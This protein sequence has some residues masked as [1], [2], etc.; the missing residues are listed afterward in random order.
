MRAASSCLAQL[1]TWMV[2]YPRYAATQQD[3]QNG[4]WQVGLQFDGFKTKATCCG[5]GSFRHLSA[6]SCHG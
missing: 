5:L 6:F 1:L 4:F 2:G 3:W